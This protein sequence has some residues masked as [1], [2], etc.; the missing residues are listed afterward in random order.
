MQLRPSVHGSL[1]AGSSGGRMSQVG[2][3]EP[4][5]PAPIANAYSR[6]F[7]DRGDP[8]VPSNQIANLPE[9]RASA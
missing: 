1:R 4:M 3:L 7:V 5:A 2:R 8:L 6:R 9:T